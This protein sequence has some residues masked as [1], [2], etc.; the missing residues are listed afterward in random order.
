MKRQCFEQKG[1]LAASVLSTAVASVS[2]VWAA[3]TGETA[4]LPLEEIV[5][6]GSRLSADIQTM[7][8]SVTLIDSDQ[9]QEQ[10]S[11]TSD[12]G[13]ILSTLVPGFGTTSASPANFHQT[14]RGR[15]PVFLV[16]GV[17]IT[18]TLNDVGREMRM[19]DP[20]VVERIEVVRGSS[21]LFGNSAGAGF[22]NYITKDGERGDAQFSTEVGVQSS[23]SSPGD[24][25]CPTFRQSI[26]GG[27]ERFDYTLIGYAEETGGYYDAD[28]DRIAPIPNGASGSADSQVYSYFGKLGYD[29]DD[30]RRLEFSVNKFRQEQDTDYILEPGDVSRGIK[31][32]AVRKPDDYVEEASQ[33]HEN[34]VSYIN[35]SDADLWGSSFTAQVYYQES[36]S[37]FGYSATRFPLT[38][39]PSAQTR[40]KSEKKGLRLD[41]HTPMEVFGRESTL[42]WG[43]DY[44]LDDTYDDLVDGRLF[45]P[46]QGLESTA[47][48]AQWQFSPFERATITAGIR[49]EDATLE[50]DDFTSLFTLARI[51]GGE[52]DYDATPVNL[53]ITY[54]L[55]DV[56]NVFFGYSE[57]FEVASAGRALRSWPVDV[58]VEILD[59][60][61][62]IVD[63]YEVGLRSNWES[64]DATVSVFYVESTNGQAFRPDP[65][66]PSE[67]VIEVRSADEVYGVEFTLN[68]ALTDALSVGGNFSWLEGKEDTDG[69]GDYDTWLSSRR[70]PPKILTA[71]I[72]YDWHGWMLR[73][74]GMYSGERKR[75]PSSSTAFYEGEIN[76]WFTLDLSATGKLGPGYLSVGVN[77]ATNTDYYTHI[78]ES[79]QQDSRNSKAPGATLTLKYR[80]DF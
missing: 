27:T 42:L 6:S 64:V 60:E 79:M 12:M 9:L 8:G 16:D 3:E 70:I 33:A 75:F 32:T 4:R 51:S 48:F 77:N 44:L 72:E 71:F 19:I 28:G 18:P 76:D 30:T 54:D 24:G 46:P 2:Q 49:Y 55:T 11:V 47:V 65:A 58:D 7:P 63:S 20:A 21:A 34:F 36:E 40:T 56:H 35:Y 43:F 14:M 23:L 29:L 66:N 53:G 10:M 50:I 5:V 78:S 69:D 74:Q 80:Y 31:A 39:K 68:A 13:A 67:N 1:R 57:G 15:K 52:L 45:A 22:I 61:P 37:I 26:E 59:P 17:P 62:N 25:L 73:A 41:F 38:E